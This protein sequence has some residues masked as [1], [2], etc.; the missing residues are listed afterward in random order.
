MHMTFVCVPCCTVLFPHPGS[1]CS[2][3][4][5]QWRPLNP[6]LHVSCRPAAMDF[7][8][9]S[10]CYFC[11]F[12]DCKRSGY[13]LACLRFLQADVSWAIDQHESGFTSVHTR[14][15]A[16]LWLSTALTQQQRSHQ[17][18]ADWPVI[19]D[20]QIHLCFSRCCNGMA[21]SMLKI[22]SPAVAARS[23]VGPRAFVAGA[24]KPARKPVVCRSYEL[25]AAAGDVDA[26][27]AVPLVA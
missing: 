8:S 2:T 21:A 13:L 15:Q 7:K 24:P 26:P 16:A 22:S 3:C 14:D 1:S 18:C 25:L 10:L 27:I 5:V 23:A 19:P 11:N 17:T 6:C 9:Y 12:Q 4:A 20:Q